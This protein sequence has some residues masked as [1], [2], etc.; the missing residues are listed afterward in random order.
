MLKQEFFKYLFVLS[1]CIYFL[2]CYFSTHY[3]F[4]KL[5]RLKF[6]YSICNKLMHELVVEVS[7]DMN[8]CILDSIVDAY[9]RELVNTNL[10]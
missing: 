1:L 10:R 4:T 3:G 8:E 6:I 5:I 7:S 9:K 2:E